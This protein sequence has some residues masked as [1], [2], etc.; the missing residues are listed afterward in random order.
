MALKATV[1]R[2]QVSL[3]NLNI[4]HY[5][6]YSLTLAKHPSETELRLM[7]RLLTFALL[8]H[9]DLQFTKGLSTDDE[10]DMWKINYD[11]SIDHWIE[12]GLPDERRIRQ[13]CGK[14][15]LVSIYTYHGNQGAQWFESIEKKLDRFNHLN[16]THFLIDNSNHLEAFVS[17]GMNLNFTIEDNEIW[18]ST[19]ADRICIK[20]KTVKT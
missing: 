13:I 9:E 20:F 12:L 6:D 15:K 18:I 19:E 1:Y 10:P 5:S 8:A 16:I 7:V 4:H 3:S 11:G 2:A 17:K 14:A